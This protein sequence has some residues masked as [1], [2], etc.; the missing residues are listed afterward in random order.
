MHILCF[1]IHLC[2]CVFTYKQI[3]TSVLI[4][5]YTHKRYTDIHGRSLASMVFPRPVFQGHGRSLGLAGACR[6]SRRQPGEGGLAWGRPLI[7]FWVA[8]LTSGY[9]CLYV[10]V[11]LYIYTHIYMYTH[12][13]ANIHTGMNTYMNMYAYIYTRTY[14]SICI[15]TYT[16]MYMYVYVCMYKSM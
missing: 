11:Y 4:S 3:Y 12:T 14:M 8:W 16:D 7:L 5:L 10:Y 9:R 15:H 13:C 6:E 2:S 1:Y